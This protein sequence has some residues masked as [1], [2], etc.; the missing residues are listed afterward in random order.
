M[1]FTSACI[2]LSADQLREMFYCS[3]Q[4]AYIA[5]FIIVPAYGF[6]QLF[7]TRGNYFGLRGIE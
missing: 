2:P 3:Y 5:H 4:L 6:Y 1:N 7:V